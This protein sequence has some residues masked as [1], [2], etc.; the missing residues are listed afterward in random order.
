MKA[1][2]FAAGAGLL[3]VLGFVE[4]GASAHRSTVPSQL[5]VGAR[6]PAL[7]AGDTEGFDVDR[8]LIDVVFVARGCPAC[9]ELVAELLAAHTRPRAGHG[10]VFLTDERWAAL[11]SLA[12]PNVRVRTGA[13]PAARAI[14]VRATPTLVVFDRATLATLDIE[15]GVSAVQHAAIRI[16]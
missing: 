10:L 13:K 16:P 1:R 7:V 11:D 15:V 4:L 9:R 14:G 6:V 3:A 5:A 2:R 8:L 12:A